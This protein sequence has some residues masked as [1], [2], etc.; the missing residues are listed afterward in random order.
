M[1]KKSTAN[2]SFVL[3]L[4]IAIATAVLGA[5]GAGTADSGGE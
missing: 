5:F 4:V 1:S 2:I 3:K